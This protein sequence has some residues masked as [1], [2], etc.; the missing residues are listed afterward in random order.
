MEN[1][2]ENMRT[3]CIVKIESKWRKK[4]FKLRQ[5]LSEK[6]LTKKTKKLEKAEIENSTLQLIIKLKKNCLKKC[7]TL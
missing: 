1:G 2:E 4:N 7:I 6:Y 5:K 3:E